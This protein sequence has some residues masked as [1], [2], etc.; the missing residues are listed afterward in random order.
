MFILLPEKGV[1]PKELSIKMKPLAEEFQSLIACPV[2]P[3]LQS[4][5]EISDKTGG[6]IASIL[7]LIKAK[8]YQLRNDAVFVAG[9]PG[10]AS[11]AVKFA[12]AKP[13]SFR[14]VI[15]LAPAEM[16]PA[17]DLKLDKMNV[18][19]FY[20]WCKSGT[21]AA[22]ICADYK[23]ALEEAGFSNTA[24]YESTEK[25]LSPDNSDWKRIFQWA[26]ELIKPKDCYVAVPKGYDKQKKYPAIIGLYGAMSNAQRHAGYFQPIADKHGMLVFCPVLP[27]IMN[28][29]EIAAQ[30]ENILA[31]A[32]NKM[33]D[34]N[35]DPKRIY[36]SSVSFSSVALFRMAALKPKLFSGLIVTAPSK[37]P[38]AEDL[39]K[40]GMSKLPVYIWQGTN[41]RLKSAG[42]NINK[43]LTELKFSRVIFKEAEG[44]GHQA[45]PV[46]DWAEIIR[47]LDNQR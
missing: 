9:F 45:P 6:I 12:S 7:E 26:A 18:S 20:L 19:S 38:D 15:L 22:Q 46:G 41:D 4:P 28:P 11:A 24:L 42:Q 14:G 40:D 30:S 8:K 1:S 34:Y 35:I 10:T 39:A 5:D 29:M 44:L 31:S 32:E 21:P 16:P 2:M 37:S 23:T 43:T 25:K 17:D 36:L 47:W 3:D 13:G 33:K 27:N